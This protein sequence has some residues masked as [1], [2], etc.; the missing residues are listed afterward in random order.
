MTRRILDTEEGLVM[1]HRVALRVV[2]AVIAL[3]SLSVSRAPVLGST[4]WLPATWA[5]IER[6][7]RPYVN[8]YVTNQSGIAARRV[9]IVVEGLD[10]SGRVTSHTMNWVG[11]EI[12]PG[13]RAYFEVRAPQPGATYRVSVL[14]DLLQ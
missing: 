2:V 13:S 7:G 5:S 4:H 9:Q 6:N 8:G 12:S 14:F 10:P 1:T 3:A 11:D